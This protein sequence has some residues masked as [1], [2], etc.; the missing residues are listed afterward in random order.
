MA[1]GEALHFSGPKSPHLTQ[2][3]AESGFSD[4]EDRLTCHFCHDNKST[5]SRLG[6]HHEAARFH[7]AYIQL[8]D[9]SEYEASTVTPR[10]TWAWPRTTLQVSGPP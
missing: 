8:Y 2:E 3:R 5:F 9:D 7:M 6:K 4:Y 10:D 1:L